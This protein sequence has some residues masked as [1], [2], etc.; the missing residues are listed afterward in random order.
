MLPKALLLYTLKLLHLLSETTP[1]TFLIA[2][3]L[4]PPLH[5]MQAAPAHH[6]HHHV[7]Q[8][9]HSIN[10]IGPAP[11]WSGC[12]LPLLYSVCQLH[13][14]R[15]II[16]CCADNGCAASPDNTQHTAM[17]SRTKGPTPNAQQWPS[18]VQNCKQIAAA[19]NLHCCLLLRLLC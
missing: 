19:P 10:A 18:N 12:K 9:S 13:R 15:C 1:A 14:W 16:N 5:R 8:S 7:T 17:T 6:H 3:C 2:S 4:L 11:L